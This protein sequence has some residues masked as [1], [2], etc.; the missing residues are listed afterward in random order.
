MVGNI[1]INSFAISEE[2]W[3]L[4]VDLVVCIPMVFTEY[5]QGK[6]CGN[7]FKKHTSDD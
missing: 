7:F 1:A 2:L 3:F 5:V 6:H 4:T